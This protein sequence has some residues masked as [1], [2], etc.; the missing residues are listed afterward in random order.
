MRSMYYE[1]H[2]SEHLNRIIRPHDRKPVAQSPT[3]RHGGQ[4]LAFANYAC[5]K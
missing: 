2:G 3:D 4:I 5:E 1:G